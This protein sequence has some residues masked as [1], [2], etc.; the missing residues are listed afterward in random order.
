MMPIGGGLSMQT[1]QMPADPGRFSAGQSG[2]IINA[3]EGVHEGNHQFFGNNPGFE[4]IWTAP[5]EII[6]ESRKTRKRD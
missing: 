1:R 3:G 2:G 4:I 6:W 5:K